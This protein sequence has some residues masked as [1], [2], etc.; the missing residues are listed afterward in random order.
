MRI[1][2][3]NG[4]WR[5]R[6]GKHFVITRTICSD[7]KRLEQ[8]FNLF[9]EVSQIRTIRIQIGIKILWFRNMQEKEWS[10]R[11]VP[12]IVSKK[13]RDY[14]LQASDVIYI[15]ANIRCHQDCNLKSNISNLST[16]ILKISRFSFLQNNFLPKL[17]NIWNPEPYV[18][19]S[20]QLIFRISQTLN[21]YVLMK[22]SKKYF[23]F[24]FACYLIICLMISTKKIENKNILKIWHF[25]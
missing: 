10:Q 21:T 16:K 3:E 17:K 11:K 23:I 4:G 24:S 7:C 12:H 1:F 22:S 19:A 18:L 2:F 5:P 13:D 14:W 8:F 6:I 15:L 20:Y 25:L 9:L